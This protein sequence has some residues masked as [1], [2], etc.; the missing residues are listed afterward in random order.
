LIDEKTGLSL[1]GSGF[2]FTFDRFCNPNSAILLKKTYL[3]APPAVYFSGDFTVI[4][5]MNWMVIP[6]FNLYIIDFSNAKQFDEIMF[7][8]NINHNLFTGIYQSNSSVSYTSKNSPISQNKKWY[9]VAFV[10]NGNNG[11]I[12][13]NG[14]VY[15]TAINMNVP[16]NVTRNFNY[17][18]KSNWQIISQLASAD[19]VYDELKIYNVALSADLIQRDYNTSSN[20]GLFKV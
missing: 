12:Y 15:A 19:A 11:T 14:I 20:N 2:S 17:I 6:D 10:L 13:L 16:R 3:Q 18:G 9:H 5:W 8:L 4:A 7:A 1:N